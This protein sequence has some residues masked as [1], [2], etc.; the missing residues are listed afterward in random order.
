M[1]AVA[2]LAAGRILKREREDLAARLCDALGLLFAALLV[3]FQIRHALNGGDPLAN[4]S[5]HIEQ[6]LFALMSLGFAYVLMRLDLAG[7]NPVFRFA[8]LAFG[9]LSAVFIVFGLGMVENPLLSSDL[10]ATVSS[11]PCC[12]PTWCRPG[13]RAA[14]AGL[15]W[16]AAALVRHRRRGSRHGGCCSA[17]SPW[18]S[19]TPSTASASIWR[20]TSAPEVWAYSVAWLALGLV[21]L[22]YG[23]VR[24]SREARLASAALVALSVGKVFLYDLTGITGLWRAL[25]VICLGAV[26]IG[27]GIVY[28][29]LVFARP[30]R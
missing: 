11:A 7:A 26:L 21:F 27:I 15:A 14:R 17:T 24:G 29:K 4:T 23:I 6:G 20:S 3:F 10:S 9:V 22:G 25:S 28:Q 30:A 1:P 5:G 19:G 8:S 2:F 12:W 13:R 16:C 18:R